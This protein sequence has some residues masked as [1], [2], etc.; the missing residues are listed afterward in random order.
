MI[1]S[2]GHKNTSASTRRLPVYS[3]KQA[4]RFVLFRVQVDA[5]SSLAKVRKNISSGQRARF[6]A[7]F[8]K[9]VVRHDW[10]QLHVLDDTRITGS[11]TYTREKYVV[12]IVELI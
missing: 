12:S 3:A 1:F 10:T 6:V 9:N 2:L 11:E 7:P 5:K 8:E 4:S